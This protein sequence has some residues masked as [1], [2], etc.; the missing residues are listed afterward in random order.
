[1]QIQRQGQKA[2]QRFGRPT[3]GAK[4]VRIWQ[5]DKGEWRL[6]KLGKRYYRKTPSQYIINIPV[7]YDILKDRDG[8]E[9]FYKGYMPVSQLSVKL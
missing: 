8:S 1:M 2:G 7:R 4:K 9:V 6:T 5:P 3:E